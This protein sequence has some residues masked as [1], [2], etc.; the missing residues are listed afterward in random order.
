MSGPDHKAHEQSWRWLAG[1]FVLAASLALWLPKEL[2]VLKAA[3]EWTRDTR[4]AV[5][6]RPAPQNDDIVIVAVT[7]DTLDALTCRLPVDRS[8]LADIIRDLDA[9]GARAIGIDFLLDTTTD[10]EKDADLRRA[11]AEAK[12]LVVP[13]WADASVGMEGKR[14]ETLKS[15]VGDRPAGYGMFKRDRF[16]GTVRYFKPVWTE[17]GAVNWHFT[18]A[19]ARGLGVEVQPKSRER[20]DWHGRPDG[21]TYT[22]PFRQY[23]A[24]HVMRL[25]APWIEGKII[26]IGPDL[27]D[28]DFHRT[29]HASA[30]WLEDEAKERPGI[31]I[32]AHVLAQLLDGRSQGDLGWFGEAILVLSVCAF[33]MWLAV[34]RF[35]LWTKV[36]IG[37]GL[38][39]G[40]TALAYGVFWMDGP[41]TPVVAPIVGF[42]IASGATGIYTTRKER[43]QRAI[44]RT[45]FSKYVPPGIVNRLE[46]NPQALTLGG[47]RRF[48]TFLFTDIEGFTSLSEGMAP[49]RLGEIITAYL[50]GIGS[51]ILRHGGTIDKFLGDGSMSFFGAPEAHDDDADRAIACACE[52]HT[53]TERF[54]AEWTEKGVPL[55]RTRIGVHAGTA[56]VGNF[57]G[58]DRFDYTALGDV[59]NTAARLEAANKHV[60][61]RILVSAAAREA[62]QR[63][64]FRPVGQ[65][66]M[67]GKTDAIMT[68]EPHIEGSETGADLE[69]Y[70]KAYA[71]LEAEDPK[72]LAAFETLAVQYPHD[73]L[74]TVHVARLRSGETGTLISIATK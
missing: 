24:H 55:G 27:A 44:I 11:I 39:A 8:F 65:L 33:G 26:L 57:G 10:P 20:I 46:R 7:E 58:Q 3:E 4:I 61:T 53:F 19:I 45:A 9:K 74:L 16:D 40:V 54:R 12:T 70:L 14:E 71:L 15:F 47:E 5:F 28:A 69:A 60:G 13:I 2:T 72:A 66:V 37:G 35:A 68:Y 1:I 42:L 64:S 67:P 51:I 48:M 62:S 22:P 52:L 50:D 6:T 21:D 43:A 59:V 56:I 36:A 25:P 18:A 34:Q 32:H 17:D 31:E 38:L 49:D 29:P 30:T 23:S 73:K 41:H 63:A